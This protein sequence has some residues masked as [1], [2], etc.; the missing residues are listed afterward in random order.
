MEA[1]F[2][3]TRRKPNLANRVDEA[4]EQAVI[5]SALEFPAY[6]QARTSNELRKQ[7]VFVSSSPGSSASTARRPCACGRDRTCPCRC[8]PL[9]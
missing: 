1:L 4:T 8:S 7:G 2:E 6:G 3:R 9:W 5:K